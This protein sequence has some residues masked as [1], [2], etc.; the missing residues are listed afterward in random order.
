LLSILLSSTFEIEKV[1]NI[2][3]SLNLLDYLNNPEKGRTFLES[4]TSRAPAQAGLQEEISQFS[5]HIDTSDIDALIEK[6]ERGESSLS[7]STLTN[8][9]DYYAQKID[10]EMQNLAARFNVSLPVELNATDSEWSVE[11]SDANDERSRLDSYLSKD[12]RL[13]NMLSQY[14]RVS[15]TVEVSKSREF[16]NQLKAESTD[17][18]TIVNYLQGV[19]NA[20]SNNSSLRI[21]NEGVQSTT[22]DVASTAFKEVTSD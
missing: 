4:Q 7:L 6:M 5:S 20:V 16:A 21:A 13:S 8:M 18:E 9:R 1:M 2:S 22:Y 11:P 15:D 10:K 3:S 14:M 12:Q 19:K 17:D